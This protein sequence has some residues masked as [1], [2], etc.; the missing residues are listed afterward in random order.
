M[1]GENMITVQKEQFLNAIKSVKTSVGK[2][3]L[4]PVLSTI[5]LKTENGGIV[6]TTTDLE[7][8]SRA[9]VLAS[10]KILKSAIFSAITFSVS[11]LDI[12]YI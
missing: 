3:A 2:L 1:K 11:L 4:Q 10:T 9:L 7:T 6:L 8:S 12:R 5:H